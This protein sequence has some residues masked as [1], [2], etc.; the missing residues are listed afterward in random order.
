MG[1]TAAQRLPPDRR[2]SAIDSGDQT[3]FPPT[4]KDGKPRTAGSVEAGAYQF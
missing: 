3:D 4:D 2:L 1:R